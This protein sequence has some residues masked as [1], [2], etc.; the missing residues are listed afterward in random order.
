MLLIGSFWMAVTKYRLYEID[1]IVSKSLTYLGL[2]AVIT[3]L[4]V[5]LV[6]GPLLVVGRS[7]DGGPGLVLPIVAHGC[8]G[9]G[10]RADSGTDAAVGESAGVR[11]S[12]DS[13]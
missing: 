10:V 2:G 12:G 13:P 3:G 1:V 4:Y 6:V 11:R 9:G 7:D 8:C 5:L